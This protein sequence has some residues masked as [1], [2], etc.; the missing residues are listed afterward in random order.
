MSIDA[1]R[2]LV[3][4]LMIVDHVR[5]RFFYHVSIGDPVNLDVASTGL[6]FT[7][8]TSHFCAPVFVFLAGLGAW[9]Y[10]HPAPGDKRSP[11]R[12]LL[13]RGIFLVVLEI[14]LINQA[15][16]GDIP[17]K[18]IY[19]QVIWAIGLSMIALA[20]LVRLPHQAIA[21]AG[22]IIVF[23]HSALTPIE[24]A[25][26]DFG[27]TLWTVLHDRGVL[28]AGEHLQVRVSYPTLPWI[29]VILCGYAFGPLYASSTASKSRTTRLLLCGAI[30]LALLLTLRGFNL[31]GETLPW[32]EGDRFVETVTSFLNYTKYPPSL[33]FLLLTLGTSFLLMAWLDT[34]DSRATRVLKTFGQ[35]PMFVYALHLYVLLICYRIVLA[36]FGAN[37]G[38]LFHVTQV[39]Q[40]WAISA[41]L[42]LALYYPARTFGEY[43]RRS[44]KSWVRYF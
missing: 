19:L 7:R 31:Y 4:L 22:L 13:T 30:S 44:N 16:F 14:V 43:K 9:L 15:W 37:E 38:E 8:L 21:A 20:V 33:D 41:L 40:I 32:D 18:T 28:F 17:P 23:G 34:K 2:G 27:Y 5:E 39:W 10:A 36:T 1:M 26:Q 12:F 11:S 24:F 29:G 6:F 42:A 3:I 35:A 25:P